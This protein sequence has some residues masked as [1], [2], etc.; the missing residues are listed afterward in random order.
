MT[1]P[2]ALALHDYGIEGKDYYRDENGLVHRTE[3]GIERMEDGISGIIGFYAF[4]NTSYDRANTFVDLDNVSTLTTAFGMSDKVHVYNASLLKTPSGYIEPNSEEAF[5]ET[6]VENYTKSMLAKIVIAPDDATFEK[7]YD[8]FI[9]Q[10]NSLGLP[11]YDAYINE[12]V[13]KNYEA[14]GEKLTDIN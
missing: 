10:L 2:E 1:S 11:K 8:E 7:L 9:N 14:A 12:A 5:I 4:M 13:Q 3:A 6:E